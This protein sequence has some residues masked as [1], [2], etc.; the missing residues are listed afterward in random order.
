MP[1]EPFLDNWT[2]LKVEFNW[3]ERLLLTAVAKQKKEAKTIERVAQTKADHATSHWWKGV[4]SL[5]DSIAFD[6]PVKPSKPSPSYQQQLEARIQ[7]S[8]Q[9]GIGLAL[10]LLCDRLNL[11]TSEK[12]I[13]LIALAPEV[14]RRYAQLFGYLQSGQDVLERPT[15]D[16]VLRLL[17]RNDA[18]WRTVRS[19]LIDSSRLMKSGLIEVEEND[20]SM[21]LSRSLKLSNECVNYLLSEPVDL[22]ALEE[23]V[24]LE[25]PVAINRSQK[26]SINLVLPETVQ[27]QLEEIYDQIRFTSQLREWGFRQSKGITA[28][29]IGASGTGKTIAIQSIAQKLGLPLTEI[30]LAIVDEPT[31]DLIDQPLLLIKSAE[32]WLT[33]SAPIAKVL[34]LIESRNGLTCFS[35]RHRLAIPSALRSRIDFTIEF[36]KPDTTARIQL[37][38]QAF[39]KE[40]SIAQIDW[41]PLAKKYALTGGEIREIAQISAIEALSQNSPTIELNHILKA[42]ARLSR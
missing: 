26:Q 2:Y 22:A 35:V 42:I 27:A 15:I 7:A 3:L 17:C 16:L 18:E 9:R 21:F 20:R 32:R 34:E 6:S 30:D 25:V 40:T 1:A 4:I 13:I 24:S 31:E 33:R 14:H 10:P 36:P 39:P 28:L 8:R 37:W 19:N 23:L 41:K 38:Q 11:T 5:E 29:L 12:N